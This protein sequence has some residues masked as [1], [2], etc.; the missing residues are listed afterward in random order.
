MNWLRTILG[1]VCVAL[2]ISWGIAFV[3]D[4]YYFALNQPDQTTFAFLAQFGA[5]PFMTFFVYTI[6]WPVIAIFGLTVSQTTNVSNRK[7]R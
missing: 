1:L 4:A 7:G 6:G 3:R 5:G 2:M